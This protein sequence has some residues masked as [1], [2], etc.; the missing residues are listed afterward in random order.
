[1]CF[2]EGSRKSGVGEDV[3]IKATIIARALSSRVKARTAAPQGSPCAITH[4]WLLAFRCQPG[5][6]IRRQ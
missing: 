5:R 1:M 2:C 6:L 4:R 3:G